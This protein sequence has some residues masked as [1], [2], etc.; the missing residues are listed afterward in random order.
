MEQLVEEKPI[1]LATRLLYLTHR[2]QLWQLQ[3]L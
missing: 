1:T 2:L 3:E